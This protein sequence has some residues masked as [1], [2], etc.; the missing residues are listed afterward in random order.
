[1]SRVTLSPEE[2]ERIYQKHLAI[3]KETTPA[4]TA[5][6]VQPNGAS[7]FMD[8]MSDLSFNYFEPYV[9]IPLKWY[10]TAFHES[11]KRQRLVS[12]EEIKMER[13][14]TFWAGEKITVPMD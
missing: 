13:Q 10:T 5:D 12:I 9:L 6:P 3:L 4:F 11:L 7:Y 1:M 14:A 2:Q 8:K